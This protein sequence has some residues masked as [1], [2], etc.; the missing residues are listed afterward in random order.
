MKFEVLGF[1]PRR[2]RIGQAI[3]LI[4]VLGVLVWMILPPNE[5]AHRGKRLSQWLDEYNRAS[6]LE[7]TEVISDAIRAMGRTVCRICWRT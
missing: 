2:P 1:M 7:K 5:P 3:F 4:A 6:A